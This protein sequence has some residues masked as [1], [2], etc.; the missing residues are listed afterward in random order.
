M[1]PYEQGFNDYVKQAGFFQNMLLT[2]PPAIG[3]GIGAGV[4]GYFGGL[5]GMVGGG[6]AGAIPGGALMYYLLKRKQ[7]SRL[8]GKQNTKHA[9]NL[10]LP[11][12]LLATAGGTA[13]YTLGGRPGLIGGGLAGA[14]AGIP[15][16]ALIRL[17]EK[18]EAAKLAPLSDADQLQLELLDGYIPDPQ[19]T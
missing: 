4:G 15:V 14:L 6:I 7:R 16:A 9:S 19:E 3:A 12:V 2:A 1:T 18:L 13:G 5:P 11:S 17:R 10:L 8:E